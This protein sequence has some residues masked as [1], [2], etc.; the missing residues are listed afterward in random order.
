MY[1]VSAQTADLQN[2]YSLSLLVTAGCLALLA[3]CWSIYRL[4]QFVRKECCGYKEEEEQNS[5]VKEA[6]NT[7][8]IGESE[9][10]GKKPSNIFKAEQDKDMNVSELNF[11][12]DQDRQSDAVSMNADEAIKQFTYHFVSAKNEGL[13]KH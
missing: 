8:S 9:I 1:G 3:I 4:V 12:E 6:K 7:K 11:D 2:S 5:Q 13:I 10:K